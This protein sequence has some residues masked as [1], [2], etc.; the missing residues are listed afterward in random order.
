MK[1]NIGAEWGEEGGPWGICDICGF[2]YRL[3]ELRKEGYYKGLLVCEWDYSAPHPQ[4][5][6]KGKRDKQYILNARPR[7]TDV[8]S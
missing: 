2:K 1:F 6:V 5:R 4:D 7:P 3:K 8:F